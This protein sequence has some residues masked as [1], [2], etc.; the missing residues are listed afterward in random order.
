MLDQKRTL[1]GYDL[2]GTDTDTD[3]EMAGMDRH[4][5]DSIEEDLYAQPLHMYVRY[6]HT[7][8]SCSYHA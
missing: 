4:D 2:D 5:E 3:S 7:P 6:S 8:Q 1:E